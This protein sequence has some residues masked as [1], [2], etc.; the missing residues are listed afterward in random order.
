MQNANVGE[1]VNHS[2]GSRS[3]VDAVCNAGDDDGDYGDGDGK[4]CGCSRAAGA[5]AG[6]GETLKLAECKTKTLKTSQNDS[7][8]QH[9]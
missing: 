2:S 8:C 4:G 5:G 7:R 1:Q 3:Q 9:A 6:P